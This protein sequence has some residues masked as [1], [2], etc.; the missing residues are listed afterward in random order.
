MNKIYTLLLMALALSLL[1]LWKSY[2]KKEKEPFCVTYHVAVHTP[3]PRN[4]LVTYT[5]TRGLVQETFVGKRWEK[6]VCLSPDEI[7]SL[8]IDEL[9][10]AENHYYPDYEEELHDPIAKDFAMK[11]LSIWI[12]HD[13]KTILSAGN[14]HLQ[15]SLLTSEIQ[16]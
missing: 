16:N 2:E 9:S 14:R 1:A 8:R 6:R 10:E 13:K 3:S 7:A 5:D 15:V 12:E 11:P 4:I